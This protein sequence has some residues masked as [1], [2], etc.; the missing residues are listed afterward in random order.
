MCTAAPHLHCAF[1]GKRTYGKNRNVIALVTELMLW[2]SVSIKVM[3]YTGQT[4]VVGFFVFF[5]SLSALVIL[6]TCLYFNFV[7]GWELFSRILHLS[8]QAEVQKQSVQ[9][10]NSNITFLCEIKCTQFMFDIKHK[11]FGEY[12]LYYGRYCILGLW[13]H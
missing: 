6:F 13:V 9:I 5:F 4:W 3:I 1:S 7:D 2:L 12:I 11:R 10:I 8:A